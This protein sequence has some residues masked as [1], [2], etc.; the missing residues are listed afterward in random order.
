MSIAELDYPLLDD[1]LRRAPDAWKDFVD[2]FMGLVLHVI[3]QTAAVRRIPLTP[4]ER[5]DLCEAV[6]RALHYDRFALLKEFDFNT[7]LAT[8]LTVVCRRLV[9]AF[10]LCEE[11]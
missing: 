5:T 7:S 2:R 8:Y 4:N 10:L 11:S 1:C 3:D 9:V 6:F